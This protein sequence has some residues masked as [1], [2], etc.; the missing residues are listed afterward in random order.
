MNGWIIVGDLATK[1]VNGRDVIV[2]AGKS[3]DIQAAIRA[4]EET[5]RRR[6]LSDLGS[7]GRL[8]DKALTR[9]NASGPSRRIEH[10]G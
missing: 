10:S 8:V 2:K 9:M 5:D 3:G 7:V 6:M 4:W 1:R